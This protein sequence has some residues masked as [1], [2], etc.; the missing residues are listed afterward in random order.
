[1]LHRHLSKNNVRYLSPPTGGL[2][3]FSSFTDWVVWG[4]MRDVSAEILFRSFSARD[5]FEQLWHG[6]GCPFFDVHLPTTASPTLQGALKDGVG[7]AVVAC[8]MPE[9][10]MQMDK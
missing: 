8:D 2:A 3:K 10:C 9:G 4:D 5:P 6:Q 1:M 7:E